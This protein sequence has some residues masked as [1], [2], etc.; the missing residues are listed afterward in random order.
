[1]VY[2]DLMSGKYMWQAIKDEGVKL[3]IPDQI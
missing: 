1:M 2:G 3:S